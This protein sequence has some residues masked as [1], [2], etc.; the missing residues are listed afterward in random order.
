MVLVD[1][2]T[3]LL[4]KIRV[5]NSLIKPVS[6]DF[7]S[8]DI[9]RASNKPLHL[10]CDAIVNALN[11]FLLNFHEPLSASVESNSLIARHS[12]NQDLFFTVL[13]LKSQQTISEPFLE[14]LKFL[15]LRFAESV[16]DGAPELFTQSHDVGLSTD[17]QSFL[18]SEVAGFINRHADKPVMDPFLWDIPGRNPVQVPVQGRFKKAPLQERKGDTFSGFAQSDGA[19]G[20]QHV[21]YLWRLDDHFRRLSREP[22]VFLVDHEPYTRT[23]SQA[24]AEPPH[25]VKLVAHHSMDAKGNGRWHVDRVELVDEADIGAFE[26]RG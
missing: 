15:I 12:S 9:N 7:L 23:V 1:G 26:L 11:K 10:M 14:Q 22:E 3:Y 16:T 17:E 2:D 21:A 20:T 18:E 25:L 19:R 6:E 13:T 8:L 4:A 24:H 5:C